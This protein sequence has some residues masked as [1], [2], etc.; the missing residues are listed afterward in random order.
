M[1]DLSKMNI[2]WALESDLIT[3]EQALEMLK[4]LELE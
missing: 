2:L 3:F 4:Q 1:T